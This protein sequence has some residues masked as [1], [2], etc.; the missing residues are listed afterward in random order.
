MTGNVLK[1]SDQ[2]S[3]SIANPG[4]HAD[5][6]AA[7]FQS[8]DVNV[9]ITRTPRKLK[10][11]P[12][13]LPPAREDGPRPI[14]RRFAGRMYESLT[15]VG[16]RGEGMTL[17]KSLETYGTCKIHITRNIVGVNGQHWFDGDEIDG[18]PVN[19][20]VELVG[21]KSAFF[22]KSEFKS[23]GEIEALEKLGYQVTPPLLKAKDR[24]EFSSVVARKTSKWM[25]GTLTPSPGTA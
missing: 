17:S 12:E 13:A 25:A 23:E 2:D 16:A 22:D 11:D 1:K 4:P 19:L 7:S 3:A 18:C 6:V 24:P 15:S 21:S 9:S 20:A 5:R 10:I 8:P 14:P